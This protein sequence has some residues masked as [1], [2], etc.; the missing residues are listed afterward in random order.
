MTE[1]LTASAGSGKTFRLAKTYIRLLF[2]SEDPNAYRHIL[3]VTFTNKATAEMKSRI[4]RELDILARTPAESD[5]HDD[6]LPVCGSDALMKMKAETLLFNLLHD[7]SAFSVSTIDSFFQMTLKA[8]AR[9]LGRFSNYQVELDGDALVEE[10]I[11]RILDSMTEKDSVLISWLSAG[12]REKL[13]EGAAPRVE[14]DL[15]KIAGDLKS[16]DYSSLL[17]DSGMEETELFSR[18]RLDSVRKACMDY[19]TAFETKA[20]AEAQAILDK[21][22]I[23]GIDP[24]ETYRSFAAVLCSFVEGTADFAEKPGDSFI[25]YASDSG[26]WFA[27]TKHRLRDA[28]LELDPDLFGNFL[29]HMDRPRILY[30]TA[31]IIR[32]QLYGLGVASVFSKEFSALAKEK[33]VLDIRDSNTLLRQII[34]DCDAPF[35]YEKIGVR[36]EHFLLDEFQDTSSVQWS[37]ILPLV[38]E[39]QGNGRDN[40]IVG[41]VKQSIYRWRGSDWRL[42]SEKVRRDLGLD[43]ENGTMTDNWRSLCNVVEF[44]NGFF[45]FAARRLDENHHGGGMISRIYEN[46]RQRYRR[47]GEGEGM[48]RFS[49]CGKERH[50]GEIIASIRDVIGNGHASYSDVAVIV[51]RN[52]DGRRIANYL[53]SQGIP[54]ISD[55]SL[56]AKSSLLV[57]DIVNLMR[58]ADNPAD[59]LNAYA[60]ENLGIS[61]PGHYRSL[62]DLAESILS[63]LADRYGGLPPGNEAYLMAFLDFV[64]E[65]S[66]ANGN[67]L[68]DFLKAWDAK[69]LSVSSPDSMDAV[70][71]LSVHKSKGLEFPY[72]IIPF[73]ETICSVTPAEKWCVPD[74]RGTELEEAAPMPF[75][76]RLSKL[77]QKS[78]FSA[79]YKE[80]ELMKAVDDINLLYVAQTRAEKAFHLIAD[81]NGKGAEMAGLVYEFV[82]G[83]VECRKPD[84]EEEAGQDVVF[85]Q[86]GEMPS[87]L[88]RGDGRD[89]LSLRPDCVPAGG[90]TS[91]DAGAAAGTRGRLSFSPDSLDFFT[92]ADRQRV[93]GVLL[94]DM[95]SDIILPSDVGKAVD[96]RLAAG[97]IGPD[98]AREYAGLIRTM[99]SEAAGRGWF[100]EDASKVRTELDIASPDGGL[101]RPDRVVTDGGKAIIII[102]YKSG[103][104]SPSH[105]EQIRSYARLYR[106]MGYEDVEACL[107]YVNENKIVYL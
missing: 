105:L 96:K 37:N 67:S 50:L 65:W 94:H 85:R 49:F 80:E 35:I 4:L 59:C 75:M 45:P 47:G 7:Y 6:L 33:N 77:A 8:F 99:V 55:E 14:K 86:I 93:R 104:E 23:A 82:S 40:L 58:Y 54:V 42:L 57:R 79:Y 95:L 25:S 13:E 41:D 43:G 81:R 27:K 18:E 103:G 66:S 16:E 90:G 83:C 21:F 36:Y 92:G 20:I 87:F 68:G 72:V 1:I 74:V 19:E 31:G 69:N 52:D 29:R 48:V 32:R 12:A 78:A 97:L 11:D 63:G 5:Y 28:M 102:D 38:A 62:F 2:S 53:I 30:N 3:A 56:M 61:V 101:H 9:E 106:A 39:S 10:C 84:R 100:P 98:E 60:A 46:C 64:T 34:G 71:I 22:S 44:N 26:K 24:A 76:V 73:A 15:K 51:R 88:K 89:F 91:E 107:W 17:S 70:R